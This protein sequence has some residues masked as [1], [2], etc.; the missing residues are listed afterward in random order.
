ML[1]SPC[2]ITSLAP[3]HWNVWALQVF[4]PQWRP[5]HSGTHQLT[6]SP[7]I[8][9]PGSR[10]IGRPPCRRCSGVGWPAQPPCAIAAASVR[11]GCPKDLLDVKTKD[12]GGLAAYSLSPQ[13]V[14]DWVS[15]L[16]GRAGV[17]LQNTRAQGLTAHGPRCTGP[18]LLVGRAGAMAGCAGRKRVSP[19]KF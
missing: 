6:T 17:Y 4:P 13:I 1:W 15:Q 7:P 10:G 8:T 14:P 5:G 18:G 12:C 11:S 2:V 16:E 19:F 9:S 3:A